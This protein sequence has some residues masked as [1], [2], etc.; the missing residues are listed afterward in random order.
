MKDLLRKVMPASLKK[1]VKEQV[2]HHQP[3]P[4]WTYAEDGLCTMHI[5]DFLHDTRFQKAYAAGKATGAWPEGDLRWRVYTALWAARQ[6]WLLDCDFVEC[7]VH[8]GGLAAAILTDLPWKQSPQRDF[9]LLDTFAGFPPEHRAVAAEV[10]RDDYRNDV[11][12]QVQ[13]HFKQ[14]PSA[15]RIDLLKTIHL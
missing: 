3:I 5:A 1:W 4:T 2:L 10:H 11:W 13:A 7:G 6:A 15:T 8:L 9:Y 14:Y 12:S